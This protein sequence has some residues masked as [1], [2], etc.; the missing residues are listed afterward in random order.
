MANYSTEEVSSMVNRYEEN[1]SRETV[2][3]LAKTLN[4]SIK[5]VIGKLSREGVY[6]KTTYVS[7]TGE[8]P[9]TKER[10]VRTVEIQ[11]NVPENS[12]SGLEKSPKGVLKDLCELTK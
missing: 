5:S 7:K 3:V 9:V 1:P 8:K 4:K 10:L 11:L 12:L 6:Q 2:E